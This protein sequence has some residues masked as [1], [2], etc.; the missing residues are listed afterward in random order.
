MVTEAN[1]S[2]PHNF[3]TDP[4]SLVLRDGFLRA[5]GTTLGADNGVGAHLRLAASRAPASRRVSP[6]AWAPCMGLA[7]CTA[8][9]SGGMEEA[10]APRARAAACHWP[11]CARAP[12]SPLSPFPPSLRLA[13]GPLAAG[14]A[15]ILAVLSLPPSTPTPPLEA[16]FTVEEEIGLLGASAL[17]ASMLT[18]RTLVNLD[19]EDWGGAAPWAGA[20]S[21]ARWAVRR[22][23]AACRRPPR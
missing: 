21:T 12:P 4:I 8:R 2:C 15:A 22:V 9:S 6:L 11:T 18:G 7:S 13:P 10:D 1:A 16:L 19:S 23:P 17:D 5:N 3:D 20:G 14:V